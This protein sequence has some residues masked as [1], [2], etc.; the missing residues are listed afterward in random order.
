VKEKN[1]EIKAKEKEIIA[2]ETKVGT[3]L[4]FHINI[5][6]LLYVKLCFAMFDC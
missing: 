5:F 6:S 4:I 1:L 3:R 2:L